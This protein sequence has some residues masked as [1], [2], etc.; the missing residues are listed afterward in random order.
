[1]IL[2]YTEKIKVGLNMNMKNIK[3]MFNIW[4]L[5]DDIKVKDELIGSVQE[6][7]YIKRIIC[8]CPVYKTNKKKNI[9]GMEYFC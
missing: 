3:M 1:M 9:G 6:Y 7:I 8:K 2:H 4:K 5:D